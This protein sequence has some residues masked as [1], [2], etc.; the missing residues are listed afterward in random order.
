MAEH[1]PLNESIEVV[2]LAEADPSGS[3]WDV[4]VIE[5][6]LSKNGN[7]YEPDVLQA[8]AGLFEGASVFAYELARGLFDHLP[9]RVKSAVGDGAGLLRNLVGALE[10]V[11]YEDRGDRK[12]LFARLKVTTP[13]VRD[14]IS[15]AW[16]SGLKDKIG[17][18]ID[19]KAQVAQEG[20]VRK[21]L[22][23]A[24][25][26]TLDLVSHPA[27]GG[28]L[29]R[30]VA[31]IHGDTDMSEPTADAP[32]IEPE[33]PVA[34]P[35]ATP[36]VA[37]API[38]ESTPTPEIDVA[39]IETRAAARL[40]A[41]V[42]VQERIAES[43]LPEP[44]RAR[45]RETLAGREF[46]SIDEAK[47]GA[48]EAI[49]TE[50][51][52]LVNV[53]GR[54]AV[55]GAGDTRESVEVG[56]ARLDRLQVAMD[57]MFEG[58]DLALDGE[59]VPRFHGLH[60]SAYHITGRMVGID[61]GPMELMRLGRDYQGVPEVANWGARESISFAQGAAF[62]RQT[63]AVI[64]S[65][66]GQILGDSVARKMQQQ[67][68]LPQ[69][70]D[71]RKVVSNFESVRDFRTQRRMILGGYGTLGTVAESN[72]YAALTSPGD[73][74]ETY[75]VAKRGGTE[76]ITLETLANDDVG[77]VRQI[78][79]RMGRAAAETLYRAV[80]ALFTANANMQD[81][82]ALFVAGHSN[83]NT[84]ALNPENLRLVVV[85]MMDQAAYGNASEILGG[86]NKPKVLLVP[87]E[88]A[89]LAQTL[90][91]SPVS[92][93]DI[94]NADN[95]A[96]ANATIPNQPDFLSMDVVAVRHWTNATDWYAV[97]DPAM[98]PTIE[99]G[100]YQGRQD[101]ELFVQDDPSQGSPFASDQIQYKIRH[102]Y[103]VKVLDW[104]GMYYNDVA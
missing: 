3:V 92:L 44:A 42:C 12:G 67:Y 28:S 45:L 70:Q 103:G 48:D 2:F 62:R 71:W 6:G 59:R 38:T 101:P 54:P 84:N 61:V 53:G 9:E 94:L 20:E 5:A 39:A 78:P 41:R 60:E 14:V 22:A 43:G 32:A 86:A 51:E 76:R 13:W 82:N 96:D 79:I 18:S 83:T 64:S 80:F 102:I 34:E 46:A 88:L 24:P 10:G 95:P 77:V 52:Y 56:N 58:K 63:E 65:T 55:S 90:T 98:Q 31:S 49:K 57:G 99:V 37:P 27:A 30:L 15:G 87:H 8:A 50:R 69:L 7:L 73:V 74:E 4:C 33:T 40:E 100:F 89:H 35:E 17:F 68:S 16:R 72:N 25:N 85:A 93:G 104:R 29:E 11:R 75:A 19:A 97:A 66:W 47:A 26:P 91:S 81:G 1:H 21:V 23:F 36:E